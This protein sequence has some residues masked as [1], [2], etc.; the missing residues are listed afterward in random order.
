MAEKVRKLKLE[1]E[2]GYLYFIDKQDDIKD[3][4]TNDITEI[5]SLINGNGYRNGIG[6][7]SKDRKDGKGDLSVERKNGLRKEIKK[8]L[9][10]Q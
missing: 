9:I 3:L 4:G 10:N 1:R 6:K 8:M 2:P 7:G 5:Q